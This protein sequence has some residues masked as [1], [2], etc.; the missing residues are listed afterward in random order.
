M[1][2]VVFWAGG[3][4][5]CYVYAGYPL[6]LWRGAGLAGARP[7]AQGRDTPRVTLIVSAFNEAAVIAEKIAQ[8][9][10]ARLSAAKKSRSWWSRMRP[11]TAPTRSSGKFAAQGVR[12]L[13]MTERGGKTLG[14]NAAVRAANGEI[15]VFSDANA[16][17]LR[18][19]DPQ[20]GAQL[21]RS[22]RRCGG[23]RVDLR[24]QRKAARRRANR[25]TGNTRP[26]SSGWRRRS[27]RPSAA[28]ARSTPSAARCIATCAPMRCPISSTRCRSS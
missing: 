9:P 20:D 3:R 18:G 8:Q 4:T 25:C 23:G 11:T 24:R 12:L 17:Y 27:A 7:V 15:V 13:R 16:M 19:C 2:E 14:L 10:R 21:R 22:G 1:L 5:G 26:A 6:L 28:T